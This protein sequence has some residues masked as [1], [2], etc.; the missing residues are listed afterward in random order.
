MARLY[1]YTSYKLELLRYFPYRLFEKLSE[2]PSH[3]LLES[4]EMRLRLFHHHSL[5]LVIIISG[6]SN[7]NAY[8]IN[9]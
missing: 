1:G 6:I 5:Q 3:I 9:K 8:A 7:E 4:I 2:Y